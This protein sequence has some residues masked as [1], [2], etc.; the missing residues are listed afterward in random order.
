MQSVPLGV[1]HAPS[2][3][4]STF[5]FSG[6]SFQEYTAQS[7]QTITNARTDLDDAD[8][9]QTIDGNA[10]F[11]LEPDSTCP[12]GKERRYPRG[13]LM[14][15]GLTDSPY[16][17]RN[18]ARFFQQNCFRV[19]GI[20]L[21]GHG[22]RP[23]D[24]RDVSWEEWA[25]AV[26]F[27]ADA[28]SA[29]S[30]Q[31]YLFGFSTGGPLS[32]YQSLRDPRI[33][34]LFLFVPAIRITPFARFAN[35][36]RLYSWIYPRG[37]WGSLMNDEDPFKYES[38]ALNGAYQ[39]HRLTQEVQSRMT[40]YKITLPLFVVASQDDATVDATATVEF[41]NQATNPG[42]RMILYSTDI[43]ATQK[44]GLPSGEPRIEKINS[45]FPDQKIISGAHTGVV[46][47][48][49]DPHYGERGDYAQCSHYFGQEAQ[50]ARCKDRGEDYL[51]EITEENL[52]RGVIRRLTYNPNDADLKERLKQFIGALP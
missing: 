7:R 12:S 9:E 21:P 25:K 46:I 34:G 5:S 40:R 30:D 49:D 16:S 19:M 2:G 27:G 28:I 36:H 23:G 1:R 29:E 45:V 33:E 11:N 8:R 52:R 14:I 38:F 18:F 48:P 50:Y 43:E 13:I 31:V 15:H 10:P 6:V 24:L 4:N 32:I 37:R 51:G 20:L 44:S 42:N 47:A 22:T 41:F 26:Q 3:L 17:T 35:L 39:V